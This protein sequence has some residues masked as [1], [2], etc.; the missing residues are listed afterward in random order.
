MQVIVGAG[1]VGTAIAHQLVEQGQKVRIVTRSGSG[2]EHPMIEKVRADA[3]KGLVEITQG[4]SVIYNCVNP[5]YTKWPELW[6]PISRAMIAAAKAND[7]VLA[8]TGNVYGYGPQPDGRMTEHT[9]LAATGVKGRVRNKMWQDALDSG[10]RTTEVRGCDYV[11]AGASGVFSA[12]IGP[13]IAK[14]RTAYVPGDPDAPHT[15]T[16]IGD[17][18]TAL[19]RLARDERAWGRAWHV[20]SAPA[21]SVRQLAARHAQLAGVPE[22]KMRKLPRWVMRT[23]GL[24][25]PMARE[26]AEMDYQFYG[27]YLLDATE[28]ARTFG[29]Q[30]TDLDV[31]IREEAAYSS[32]PTPPRRGSPAALPAATAVTPPK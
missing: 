22:V 30:P 1:P 9:P 27:P 6:P 20:P 18:A 32:S 17:M 3:A 19:V 15:W 14:G 29:L 28:T 26:L 10:I 7:A 11:G 25:V 13:A 5:P 16:Y 4:A 23:A 21:E 31:A 12:V 24:A 2:P 8:I